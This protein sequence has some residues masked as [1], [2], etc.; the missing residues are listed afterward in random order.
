MAGPAGP[1]SG[2]TSPAGAL[3]RAEGGRLAIFG[4]AV[5]AFSEDTWAATKMTRRKRKMKR[6]QE[7]I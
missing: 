5:K 2:N 4:E 1:A 3:A 6:M 7:G